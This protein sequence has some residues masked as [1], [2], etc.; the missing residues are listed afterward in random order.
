MNFSITF[1]LF[2][3]LKKPLGPVSCQKGG[4]LLMGS[5][6]YLMLFSLTFYL[7]FRLRKQFAQVSCQK[8]EICLDFNPNS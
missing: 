1:D 4:D 7:F 8:V 2:F 6:H 5:V 3:Q